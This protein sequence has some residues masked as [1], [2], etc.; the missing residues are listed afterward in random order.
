[1]KNKSIILTT[2]LIFIS[3]ESLKLEAFRGDLRHEE[4]KEWD[5]LIQALII[6][7]SEGNQ[8]AEGKTN[9]VGILQITPIYVKEVNRILNEKVYLLSH[10]TDIEKSLEMFEIYQS[11][12]NPTRDILRAIKIHNPGAGK[13]YTD[14]VMEQFNRLRL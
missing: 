2:I 8:F 12:H 10:R 14:K 9:D 13:W 4:P 5:V 6:V 1:M 3:F 7:E 11:H